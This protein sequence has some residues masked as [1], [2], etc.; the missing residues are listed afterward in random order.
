MG[1]IR[2][3]FEFSNPANRSLSP[4]TAEAKAEGLLD[5]TANP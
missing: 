4:V 3:A 5:E 1:I 2:T